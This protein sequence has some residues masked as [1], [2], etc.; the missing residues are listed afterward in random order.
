MAEWRTQGPFNDIPLHDPA[1]PAVN[2]PPREGCNH[3]W[4][5][6]MGDI[7][8]PLGYVKCAYCHGLKAEA[9]A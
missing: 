3:L 8:A 1:C 5:G 9:D 4:R 2:Q 6:D 7:T